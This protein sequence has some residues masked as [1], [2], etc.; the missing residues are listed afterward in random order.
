M[1]FLGYVVSSSGVLTDEDKVKAIVDWPTPS[2]VQ[3]VRS[4]HGLATFYRRFIRHFNSIAAP[5]TNCLK[6]KVF[7]WTPEADESFKLL[8]R[9]LTEAP[10]LALPDFDKTFEL[11]CDASGVGIVVVLR[12]GPLRSLVKSGMVPSSLYL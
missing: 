6:Q 2:S 12:Q 8:K 11:D 5:L 1:V 4:F 10:I 9:R 7:E 3:E